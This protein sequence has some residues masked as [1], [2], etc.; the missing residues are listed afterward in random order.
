MSALVSFFPPSVALFNWVLPS[1]TGELRSTLEDITIFTNPTTTGINVWVNPANMVYQIIGRFFV[2]LAIYGPD[3][4]IEGIRS[5]SFQV[6]IK[7]YKSTF[8]DLVKNFPIMT[9]L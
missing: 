5:K 2:D 1:S 6:K 4:T 9:F 7:S 8:G 3:R